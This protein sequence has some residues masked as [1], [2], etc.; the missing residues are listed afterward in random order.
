MKVSKVSFLVTFQAQG[1]QATRVIKVLV[2][3]T[4]TIADVAKQV[5]IK[6]TGLIIVKSER[7]NTQ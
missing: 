6:Q 5:K 4:P 2:G 1:F 7:I 3:K